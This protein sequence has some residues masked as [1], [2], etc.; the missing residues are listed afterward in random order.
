VTP[1][2]TIDDLAAQLEASG[3]SAE[4]WRRWL[5]GDA[6]DAAVVRDVTS[7]TEALLCGRLTPE[8]YRAR[9]AALWEHWRV[10][11]D[12]LP[13]DEAGQGG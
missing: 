13:P 7:A 12:A 4:A 9:M 10:R 2:P 8:G 6:A 3:V 5:H 11:A 1:V